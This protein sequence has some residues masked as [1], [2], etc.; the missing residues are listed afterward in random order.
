MPLDGEGDRGCT[1][2]PEV[3]AVVSVFPDVLAI[4]DQ[5]SPQCLLESGVE[6][7]AVAGINRSRV[8][9]NAEWRHQGSKKRN[10]APG[11]GD[12]Q[13]LVEGRFQGARV[14]N[15]KNG[16]GWLNV[17]RDPQACFGL[18]PDG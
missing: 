13:I 14:R 17:V 8:T 3:V 15:S 16:V 11:T 5:V 18:T 4:D 10:I 1:H 9:G 6:F 12:N 7:I 2:H